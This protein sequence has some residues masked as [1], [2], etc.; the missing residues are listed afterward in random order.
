MLMYYTFTPA[1]A[2]KLVPPNGSELTWQTIMLYSDTVF[3]VYVN[4]TICMVISLLQDSS[5]SFYGLGWIVWCQDYPKIYLMGEGPRAILIF[6]T[7]L[8][9][10]N[11]LI[12]T[13]YGEG[14]GN[15]LQC[16][17]LENPR[18][19]G[20]WWAAISGVAQGRTR[21]KRLSNSSSSSDYITSS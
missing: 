3:L 12:V 1:S 10:I 14:N 11:R 9:F 6:K 17:C 18:D 2:F 19:G 15:P 8:S 20:A 21:L 4:E 7:F 16:S 5:Q 13:I